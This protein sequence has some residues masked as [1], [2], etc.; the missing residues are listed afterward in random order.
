MH[1]EDLMEF[2]CAAHVGQQVDGPYTDRCGVG[3]VAEPEQLKTSLVQPLAEYPNCRVVSDVNVTELANLR[4]DLVSN[5]YRSIVFMDYQ[6][7]WERQSSSSKN[8]EGVLR[9]LVCEGWQGLAHQAETSGI[10]G[11]AFVVLCITP[12]MWKAKGQAWKES[13][14][15]SRFLWLQYTIANPEVIH[16]AQRRWE[17][18]SLGTVKI[19]WPVVKIPWT[20]TETEAETCQAA[21]RD[22]FGVLRGR[23]YQVLARAYNVLKWHYR[24]S[25][26]KDRMRPDQILTG[27]GRLA[28]KDGGELVVSSDLEIVKKRKHSA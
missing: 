20:L 25:R 1:V 15:S 23:S 14:F 6:K 7:V 16:L 18:V 22:Q 19:P 8:I 17:K 2:L 4:G 28:C 5:R 27:I 9:S 11:R 26:G 24:H 3:L 21:V 10:P 12:G 13:G